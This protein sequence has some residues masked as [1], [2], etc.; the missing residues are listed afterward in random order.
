MQGKTERSPEVLGQGRAPR[1]VKGF[2]MTGK[3][4]FGKRRLTVLAASTLGLSILTGWYLAGPAFAEE[5]SAADIAYQTPLVPGTP[6]TITT[7]SCVDLESQKAWLIQD[8]KI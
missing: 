6:C 4:Q 7:K 5:P 1:G 3:R 2:E 8:G